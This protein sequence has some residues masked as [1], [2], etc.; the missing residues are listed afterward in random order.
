MDRS[1]RVDHGGGLQV[2]RGD[3]L[4]LH[5][6]DR[7]GD[8]G[9]AAP[10][11]GHDDVGAARA[12]GEQPVGGLRVGAAIAVRQVAAGRRVGRC[13]DLGVS[14]RREAELGEDGLDRTRCALPH[15]NDLLL[16]DRLDPRVDLPVPLDGHPLLEVV[17]VVV[18]AAE[19]VVVAGHDRIAGGDEVGPRQELAHELRRLADLGVRRDR[20]VA[21]CDLEVEPG[22]EQ[23][24]G[25]DLAC[26]ARHGEDEGYAG[27]R[28]VLHALRA[29][30]AHGCEAAGLQVEHRVAERAAHQ[31]LGAAA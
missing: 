18:A 23:V 27:D 2:V 21:G 11:E 16:T 9:E 17:R 10:V 26:A 22:G 13:L 8:V 7:L 5:A 6:D 31:R 15:R 24:L 3:P 14:D 25:Q 12:H 28:S 20:V 19:H 30:R 29:G 4:A 1:G